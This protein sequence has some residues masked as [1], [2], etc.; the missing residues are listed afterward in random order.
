MGVFRGAF[1]GATALFTV[2]GLAR[3]GLKFGD[4]GFFCAVLVFAFVGFSR[5]ENSIW[6]V[7]DLLSGGGWQ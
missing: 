2:A 3:A 5:F 1:A 4:C 7:A 6:F